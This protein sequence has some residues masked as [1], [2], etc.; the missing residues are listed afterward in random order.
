M[1][2]VPACGRVF[3]TAVLVVGVPSLAKST[4]VNFV[5]A[6]S[7]DYRIDSVA[8]VPV[9]GTGHDGTYTC[10]YH[11]AISCK[12]LEASLLPG[13]PMTWDNK[14]DFCVVV[15]IL[16]KILTGDGFFDLPAYDDVYVIGYPPFRVDEYAGNSYITN[17]YYENQWPPSHATVQPTPV[18]Y[19]I[20]GMRSWG[21]ATPAV[22]PEASSLILFGRGAFG[23][24]FRALAIRR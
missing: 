18:D 16:N 6:A 13:T 15:E 19:A 23:L 21:T 14:E 10:K 24:S 1:S 8:D 20:P 4:S 22:V 12:A 11:H 3:F 9:T 17:A 7:G 2:W 5:D